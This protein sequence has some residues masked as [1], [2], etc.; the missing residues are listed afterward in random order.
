[1]TQGG[2]GATRGIGRAP[3]VFVALALGIPFFVKIATGAEPYPAS[4]LPEGGSYLTMQHGSVTY[5]ITELLAQNSE[6]GLDQ[7]DVADLLEPISIQ[8]F[9]YLTRN[10][11]GLTH[12]DDHVLDVRGTNWTI[13]LPRH[14]PSAS[15]QDEVR[16]WL[17]GRL[18]EQGLGSDSLVIRRVEVTAAVDTGRIVKRRTTSEARFDL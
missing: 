4:I 17:R 18:S 2:A 10:G 13:T 9:T 3:T 12:L 16:E 5:E 15:E 11:F 8:Y 1:M 14:H 7:V 6:G